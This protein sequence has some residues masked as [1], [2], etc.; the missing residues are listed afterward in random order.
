M[1]PMFSI[2]LAFYPELTIVNVVFLYCSP[3]VL[4]KI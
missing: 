2:W 4:D 3:I 1:K